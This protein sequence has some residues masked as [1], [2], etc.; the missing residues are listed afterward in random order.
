V[1]V[2]EATN[3][4]SQ[5]IFRK[6]GFTE[7]VRGSYADHRF[8]GKAWFTSIDEHGGPVLMDKFLV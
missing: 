5:H 3:K 6:L 1:A 7:R 4:T 8:E 2:T